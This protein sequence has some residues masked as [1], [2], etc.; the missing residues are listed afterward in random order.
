MVAFERG[1]TTSLLTHV[2]DTAASDALTLDTKPVL[3][4]NHEAP[5]FILL[6]TL[7]VPA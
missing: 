1:S 3:L 4:E 2:K 5:E 6:R 7:V